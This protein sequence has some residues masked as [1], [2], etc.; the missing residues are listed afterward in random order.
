MVAGDGTVDFPFGHTQRTNNYLFKVEMTGW[1]R[2]TLF[3]IR[4]TF[5]DSLLSVCK[6]KNFPSGTS[7][8]SPVS[9]LDGLDSVSRTNMLR[10]LGAID[11]LMVNNGPLT[12]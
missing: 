9:L 4:S 11:V 5:G 8:Y 6:L 2:G 3:K 7:L 10:E 1:K 12:L